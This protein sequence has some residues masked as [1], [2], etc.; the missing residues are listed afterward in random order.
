MV[1][2]QSLFKSLNERKRPEDV[3]EMVAQILQD[4]LSRTEIQILDKAAKH[5]LRRG[6]WKY[7]S[8]L[9]EFSRPIGAQRQIARAQDLFETAYPLTPEASSDPDAVEKFIRDISPE[10]RKAFGQNDFKAD[11]LN[12]TARRE[13]GLDLS[14]RRYNKLFRL[15]TRMESKLQTLIREI[16]KYEFTRIGKS[17]LAHQITWEDFSADVNTA[18][19]IAYYTARCNLRSEFTIYGQQRPYDEI[20]DMLFQRCKAQPTTRWWAIA[21]VY[22][23]DDVLVHLSDEQKGELLGKWFSI[24]QDIAALLEEIWQTSNIKRET[25]VVQRGND[26]T[27]WNNTASAWNK[28]RDHWMSLVYALGME[29]LLQTICFGKVLRLMAADVVAWH[30]STGGSLDPNTFV[31]NELPLPWEVLNGNATCMLTLVEDT[32][33][34]HNVDPEKSGWIAPRPR[35]KV[36]V[37][38]PTPEL[39]HGV[40]VQNPWL[41]QSLRDAG[42]FS[43]KRLTREPQPGDSAVH[44]Q[45]MSQHK[46]RLTNQSEDT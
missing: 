41:A 8:M 26:S 6:V 13:G 14:R 9:Q 18:C 25:M 33:R 15:L 24:L 35:T 34:N 17:G 19:F 40:S 39:V 27:T 45:V 28:A 30:L 7:T 38:H 37:F 32:C 2:M 22:P 20:A 44:H 43:G 11:R 12:R 1:I 21:H 36:A 46:K 5:S 4:G 16:K 42:F 3:A 10:I 29:E 31:W 23:H